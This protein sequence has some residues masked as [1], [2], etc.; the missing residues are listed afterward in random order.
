MM[1]LCVC[2]CIRYIFTVHIMGWKKLLFAVGIFVVIPAYFLYTP[3]PAGY[4]TTSACKMQ[5][6]LAAL[7]LVDAAVGTLSETVM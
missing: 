7:K 2:V 5:M 3:I 6:T 1:V 4:S